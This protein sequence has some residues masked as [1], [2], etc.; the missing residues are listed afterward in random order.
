MDDLLQSLGTPGR[1]AIGPWR[2]GGR[3]QATDAEAFDLA[4]FGMPDASATAEKPPLPDVAQGTSID[5][6]F[7]AS[8]AQTSSTLPLSTLTVQLGDEV[9]SLGTMPDVDVR[10]PT[11]GVPA[12]GTFDPLGSRFTQPGMLD[13]GVVTPRPRLS[14]VPAATSPTAAMGSTGVDQPTGASAGPPFGIGTGSG[15]GTSG[16]ALAIEGAV[17]ESPGARTQSP[18]SVA[19]SIT[20][21][22]GAAPIAKS[23]AP[24][25]ALPTPEESGMV[26]AHLRTRPDPAGPTPDDLAAAQTGSGPRQQ[27][28]AAFAP[29]N[30]MPRIEAAITPRAPEPDALTQTATG[31]AHAEINP[32]HARPAA[33]QIPSAPGVAA[34]LQMHTMSAPP[35]KQRIE[36]AS[37]APVP[38]ISPDASPVQEAAP[39]DLRPTASDSDRVGERPTSDMPRLTGADVLPSRSGAWAAPTV[40][41]TAQHLGTPPAATI[42]STTYAG[43]DVAIETTALPDLGLNATSATAQT[44]TPTLG[45]GA[46][47]ASTPA[48]AQL[49]AH[50]IAAALSDGRSEAGGPVELT[51]DPP[52]L[53]RLRMHVTEIAGVMTLTIHADRPE[54]ADLMRRHLDLLAQEFAEAGL[55][56]PSVRISQDN[57]GDQDNRHQGMSK[58]TDQTAAIATDELTAQATAPRTGTGALDL[59]L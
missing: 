59:R 57:S 10:G 43:I 7:G 26:G 28:G 3:E 46:A 22:K 37:A 42:M 15:D 30:K 29:T 5:P 34:S 56:A 38:K 53:G 41:G 18:L 19:A 9:V 31:G 54:T 25:L 32:A 40:T 44:T 51:L 6:L 35:P 45:L 14:A 12:E 49:V 21:G 16:P 48:T 2:E 52:E 23:P 17:A 50:Q 11:S 20:G 27:S 13:A 39:P 4:F 8:T 36:A 55:D 33:A 24:D 1:T 58:Q 47:P